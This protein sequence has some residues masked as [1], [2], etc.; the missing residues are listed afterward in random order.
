MKTNSPATVGVAKTQPPLSNVQSGRVLAAVRRAPAWLSIEDELASK[1]ARVR[2]TKFR[3]LIAKT[4]DF[5]PR[6]PSESYNF[7]RERRWIERSQRVVG[8]SLR[9][10]LLETTPA[11]RRTNEAQD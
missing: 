1:A 9:I 4:S 10:S 7:A 6:R 8:E 3:G 2:Q 5:Y 11:R